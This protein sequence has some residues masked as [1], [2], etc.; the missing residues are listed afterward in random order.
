MERSGDPPQ[1]RGGAA[2]ALRQFAALLRKNLTLTTRRR[3]PLGIGG[4]GGLLLQVRLLRCS[5]GLDAGWTTAQ[6]SVTQEHAPARSIDHAT[7]LW[8]A[9][10]RHEAN[11]PQSP[12][13]II[14]KSWHPMSLVLVLVCEA[15]VDGA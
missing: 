11:R 4:W 12:Q 7:F 14:V 2:L 3:T 13:V 6:A 1:W 8:R 15:L 10:E 9:F 5:F